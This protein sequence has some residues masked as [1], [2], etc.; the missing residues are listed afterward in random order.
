MVSRK[1]EDVDIL[2]SVTALAILDN[3]INERQGGFHRGSDGSIRWAQRDQNGKHQFF[4]MIELLQLDGPF[5]PQISAVVGFGAGCVATLTE[6]VRLRCETLL[7]RGDE[8]VDLDLRHLL[9]MTRQQG[10]QLPHIEE[11]E[12]EVM[13]GAV[14]MLGDEGLEDVFMSN[15]SSFEEREGRRWRRMGA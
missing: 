14:M 8:W 13:V 3:A 4:V 11:E 2:V 1:T 5:A 10:L 6:L 9:R 15:L 7:N 12:M